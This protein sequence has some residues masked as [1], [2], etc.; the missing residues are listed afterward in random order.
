MASDPKD[1]TRSDA[2]EAAYMKGQAPVLH[3]EKVV[4]RYH[5]ILLAPL[6]LVALSEVLVL[7]GVGSKPAPQWVGLLLLI[8]ALILILSW[9]LFSVLRVHVTK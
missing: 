3:R 9:L 6:V 1:A 5:Y 8:P 4:W 2:Y 7:A